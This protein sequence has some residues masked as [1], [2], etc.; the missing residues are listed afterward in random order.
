MALLGLAWPCLALVVFS[1]RILK[2]RHLKTTNEDTPQMALVL[3]ADADDPNKPKR[4][5]QH[6]GV[7]RIQLKPSE[8]EWPETRDEVYDRVARQAI[9]TTA[10]ERLVW[11]NS[12]I[13]NYKWNNLYTTKLN[14][15]L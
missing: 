2:I 6:Q 7:P 8:E 4:K 10:Q 14:P 12:R 3:A 13:A 11:A 15:F 9:G 5:K 1:R